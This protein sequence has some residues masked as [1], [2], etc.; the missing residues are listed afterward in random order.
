[1]LGDAV[2]Y[3]V[4]PDLYLSS[5]TKPPPPS[6][7]LPPLLTLLILVVALLAMFFKKD[8]KIVAS[9]ALVSSVGLA[10]HV[11]P[12]WWPSSENTFFD[13]PTNS[14]EDIAVLATIFSY[15]ATTL[16]ALLAGNYVLINLAFG[17]K[18][19]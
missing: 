19:T 7:W 17:K 10:A 1:M 13:L 4:D 18:Q 2:S 3:V 15:L 5:S 6:L 14:F 11:I 8:M 16:L 12:M 9:A